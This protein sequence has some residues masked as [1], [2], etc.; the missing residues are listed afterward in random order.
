[1]VSTTLQSVAIDASNKRSE[2]LR[3]YIAQMLCAASPAS[4]QVDH[5][6][7]FCTNDDTTQWPEQPWLT[8]VKENATTALPEFLEH[9]PETLLVSLNSVTCDHPNS[10]LQ[11]HLKFQVIF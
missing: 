11:M 1:M 4:Q 6:T 3:P 5:V 2:D 8:I 9:N 7:L 10:S